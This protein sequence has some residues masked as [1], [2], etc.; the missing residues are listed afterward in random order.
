MVQEKERWV[1]VGPVLLP[2]ERRTHRVL[3]RRLLSLAIP[4]PGPGGEAGLCLSQEISK[5]W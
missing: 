1:E 3:G 5:L 4:R 2:G